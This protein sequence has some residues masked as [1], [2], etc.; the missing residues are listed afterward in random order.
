M[1]DQLLFKTCL[2]FIFS[3]Q[4]QWLQIPIHMKLHHLSVYVLMWYGYSSRNFKSL[5]LPGIGCFTD[6]PHLLFLSG[7][8]ASL[9]SLASK[10]LVIRE[11]RIFYYCPHHLKLGKAYQWSYSHAWSKARVHIFSQIQLCVWK[12][13]LG[14]SLHGILTIR[15]TM[16]HRS[17]PFTKHSATF[18]PG[19]L[20]MLLVKQ[21]VTTPSVLPQIVSSVPHLWLLLYSEFLPFFNV[22]FM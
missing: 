20:W 15:G 18:F 1:K 10:G 14:D 11:L 12:A 21:P 13:H 2:R 6:E 3:T 8:I 5:Q 7:N 19:C 22:I 9:L 17:I 16:D 4:R